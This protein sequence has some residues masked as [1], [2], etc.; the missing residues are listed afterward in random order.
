MGQTRWFFERARG[1]YKNERSREGRTMSRLRAFDAQNPRS[2][3]FTKEDLAKYANAYSEVSRSN[4]IVIGPN[5]VVKGSQKNHKDFIDYNLPSQVD[6]IYFEDLVAKAL[7]FKGAEKAYG[8]KPNA[9]GDMRYVT[10]PYT[11]SYLNYS[12][13]NPLDLYG[14]WKEQA[15]S[16]ELEE[17]LRDLMIKVEHFIKSSAPG[18][19]YGEW[20]KKDECWQALKKSKIGFDISKI[21]RDL[22]D[23]NTLGTRKK[24]N[25]EHLNYIEDNY[26]KDTIQAISKDVWAVI[27]DWGKLENNLS[28]PQLDRIH[29]YL[30]SKSKDPSFP[31]EDV[32][33]LIE[34]I[35]LVAQK[36]PEILISEA[37]EPKTDRELLIELAGEMIIWIKENRCPL[38]REQYTYLK[39]VR[40]EII[41]FSYESKSVVKAL[42]G[43]IMQYGFREPTAEKLL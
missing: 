5:N 9:I 8:V 6:N 39:E 3:F 31:Q 28:L 35:D 22:A 20:A 16:V 23:S 7:L 38:P 27:N 41:H 4:K 2:Q 11:I 25:R 15:I 42:E 43:Y 33:T 37:I 26:R 13:K 34:I 1:Q 19:L 30:H 12:L 21:E 24:I 17:A 32:N 10:V 36:A 18:S 29:N 40:D 14:I